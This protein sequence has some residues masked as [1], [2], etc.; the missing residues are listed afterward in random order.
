MPYRWEMRQ[1]DQ[2]TAM[3]DNERIERDYCDPKITHRYFP[4]SANVLRLVSVSHKTYF[5]NNSVNLPS[6]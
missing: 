4:Y 5:R 6:E 3:P 1:D 2:W